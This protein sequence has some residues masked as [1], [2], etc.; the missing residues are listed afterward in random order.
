[1][2][3]LSGDL[4]AVFRGSLWRR[5]CVCRRRKSIE[6]FEGSCCGVLTERRD[7]EEFSSVASIAQP[8]QGWKPKPPGPRVAAHGNPGLDDAAPSGLET[9]TAWPQGS[10]G[11]QPWAGRRNPFGVECAMSKSA[12]RIPVHWVCSATL[13]W[14]TQPLHG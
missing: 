6:A 14:T 9:E 3:L 12:S 2:R 10:R 1:M 7:R 5:L 11:R 8:L 13:G 4:A